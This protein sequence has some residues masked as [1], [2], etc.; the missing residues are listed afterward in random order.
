[1]TNLLIPL[2][3]EPL[4][5]SIVH[6]VA[7]HFDPEATEVT[8]FRLDEPP[9]GL[10]PMPEEKRMA[11]LEEQTMMVPHHAYGPRPL[12]A[13][14]ER[15]ATRVEVADS[16]LLDQR[17]AKLEDELLR[18]GQPL[19]AAGFTVSAAVNLGDPDD[20]G[21]VIVAFAEREEIDT[22]ALATH[23]ET[24][25]I[26]LLK[27]SVAFHVMSEAPQPII[28]YRPDDAEQAE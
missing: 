9:Q 1:M 23:G 15:P 27:G 24:G 8:L 7:E 10:T 5:Q 14:K 18:I 16:Q 26:R 3:R 21:D 11:T 12:T 28:L 20:A 4:S 19:L 13:V 6:F 2:T 25:I 17:V 22:I